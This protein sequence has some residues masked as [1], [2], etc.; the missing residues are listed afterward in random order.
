VKFA[1][2]TAAAGY[3]K[4]RYQRFDWSALPGGSSSRGSIH[5]APGIGCTYSCFCPS[6]SPNGHSYC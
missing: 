1:G 4:R 5:S 3:F 6:D 2:Y